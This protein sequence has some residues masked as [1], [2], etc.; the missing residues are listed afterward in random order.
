MPRSF[1]RFYAAPVAIMVLAYVLPMAVV[2]AAVRAGD[3][4]MLKLKQE[5]A[6]HMTSVGPIAAVAGQMREGRYVRAI[7]TIFAWN[8]GVA[9]VALSVLAG[10]VFFAL[11]PVVG[12]SRGVLLGLFYDPSAFEGA[13]GVVT[14]GT[15]LLELP[16]Y[17]IAGALGMRLGL[18]WLLPPRK[19]RLLEAWGHARWTIPVVAGALLVA[20]VW[21]VTGLALVGPRH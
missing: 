16:P 10:G 1:L 20:A 6:G 2:G 14:I 7:L 13:R 18:A 11:P 17:M 19:E 21:E 4:E 9:A 12:V 8:F 15:A 5:V 3:P